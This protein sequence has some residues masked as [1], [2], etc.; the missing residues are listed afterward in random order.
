LENKIK[1]LSFNVIMLTKLRM[2]PEL[3]AAS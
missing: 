3:Q 2:L 1:K